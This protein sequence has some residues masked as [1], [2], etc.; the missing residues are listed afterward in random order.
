[1]H[2]VVVDDD[3]KKRVSC[4]FGIYSYMV[5]IFRDALGVQLFREVDLFC[6][7]VRI[8]CQQS[9]PDRAALFIRR[10]PT[11]RIYPCPAIE[12]GWSVSEPELVKEDDPFARLGCFEL[13]LNVPHTQAVRRDQLAH[14]HDAHV[15]TKNG[16]DPG[17]YRW[18]D[19]KR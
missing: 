15:D 1:M 8:Y 2:R 9:I 13:F 10:H 14:S 4:L 7:I 17:Y 16:Y 12:D 19:L 6:P 5:E 3:R 18:S 11:A